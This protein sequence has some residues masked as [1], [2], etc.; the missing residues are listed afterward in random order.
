VETLEAGPRLLILR[1]VRIAELLET[2]TIRQRMSFLAVLANFEIRNDRYFDVPLPNF[3]P[4][5]QR[6]IHSRVHSK[7]VDKSSS[8]PGALEPNVGF[9]GTADIARS[10]HQ[11]NSVANDPKRTF[12]QLQP[13]PSSLL[14]GQFAFD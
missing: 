5:R 9:R 11:T 6:T 14:I 3:S 8:T 4:L 7:R 13:N 12:A 1:Q 10:A 2:R